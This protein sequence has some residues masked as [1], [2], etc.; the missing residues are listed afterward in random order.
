[1]MYDDMFHKHR[2]EENMCIVYIHCCYIPA[3]AVNRYPASANQPLQD[4]SSQ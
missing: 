4:L 3:E 2:L 1:M